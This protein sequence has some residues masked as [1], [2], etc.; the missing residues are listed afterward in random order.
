MAEATSRLRGGRKIAP[1][2]VAKRG[3]PHH[4]VVLDFSQLLQIR[5]KL[6]LKIFYRTVPILLSHRPLGAESSHGRY[7]SAPS[8]AKYSR[9]SSV[10]THKA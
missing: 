3:V 2:R 5:W 4:E 10:D 6:P 8:I 7:R 9:V 1:V